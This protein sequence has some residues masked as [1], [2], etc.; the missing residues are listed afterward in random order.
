V[1]V[2]SQ[3]RPST[4][5]P[6][7]HELLAPATQALPP[8]ILVVQ[9]PAL[10]YAVDAQ[11]L[12]LAQVRVQAP[13]LH[14]PGEQSVTV[15]G[16]QSGPNCDVHSAALSSDV[17]D[18]HTAAWQVIPLYCG[19]AQT[20]ATHE[21]PVQSWL[22]EEQ[23]VMSALAGF[24]QRPVPGLHEPGSWHSSGCGQTT[25]GPETQVPFEQASLSVQPFP[26]LQPVPLLRLLHVPSLPG[27]L[28]ATQSLGSP[29][30][31]A[32][33][34]HLPSTQPPPVEHSRQPATLQS[35]LTSQV[36]AGPSCGTQM[37]AALQKFPVEQSV[38]DEQP[39][40]QVPALHAPAHVTTAGSWQAPD[41]QLPPG[42]N[43]KVPVQEGVEHD[44]PSGFLGLEQ[45]PV[46]VL[47]VPGSWHA[48]GVGHTTGAP[49]TQVPDEQASFTVH[50]FP[51]LHA[52]ALG[53]LKQVPT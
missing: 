45:T 1:Q 2:V 8:G 51:S 14:L 32:V 50:A 12:S 35:A 21:S 9:V 23:G 31:H 18:W 47:Q 4:Q 39:L 7:A 40:V 25:E 46:L 43:V 16:G 41:E 53:T 37:P 13:P 11:S 44:V 19:C 6:V 22:S 48:S 3:H 26:S 10:Q 17:A 38:S 15:C 5:L 20:P 29:P 27:T 49:E 34:Q 28:Q 30:A 24:E 36:P 42:C 33:S 52:V